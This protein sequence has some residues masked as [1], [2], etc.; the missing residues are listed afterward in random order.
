MAKI[1]T[2]KATALGKQS[3]EETGPFRP[4]LVPL[5]IQERT[6]LRRIFDNPAYKKAFTNA[7]MMKPSAFGGETDGPLAG[8]ISAKKLHQIQGWELFEAALALQ[9]DDPKPPRQPIEETF[10]DDPFLSS[11]TPE[12]TKPA[13]AKPR[14]PQKP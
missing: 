6:E 5:T 2:P 1:V 7:R 11:A 12:A 14:N 4:K 13:P 3:R 10:P 8:V 9:A